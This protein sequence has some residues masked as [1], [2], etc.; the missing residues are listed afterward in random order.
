MKGSPNQL[1]NRPL[2]P[3]HQFWLHCSVFMSWFI[4][5]R[6]MLI[7]MNCSLQ[8]CTVLLVPKHLM[9]G[10]NAYARNYQQ[11]SSTAPQLRRKPGTN[12]CQ[13]NALF[14]R[15]NKPVLIGLS[16]ISITCRTFL[17]V[18]DHRFLLATWLTLQR[19]TYLQD[20][21]TL[22]KPYTALLLESFQ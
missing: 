15:S 21:T 11:Y 17:Y 9:G 16:N 2:S 20:T 10:R 4:S 5:Y 22:Q 6:S 8:L 18:R 19:H 7:W 14:I 12:D 1:Q 3:F 13:L